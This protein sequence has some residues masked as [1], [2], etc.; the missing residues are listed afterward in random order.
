MLC[1]QS[2]DTFA[3]R[4]IGIEWGK[5]LKMWSPKFIITL[6]WT[7]DALT[8]FI[9]VLKNNLWDKHANYWWSVEC[10]RYDNYV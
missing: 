3:L 10:D 4:G 6:I 2:G 5:L 8:H 1:K 7:C 9:M